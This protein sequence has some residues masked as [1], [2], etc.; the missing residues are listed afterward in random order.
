[1]ISVVSR[2]EYGIVLLVSLVFVMRCVDK[3]F[4][5]YNW[6][7]CNNKNC[8]YIKCVLVYITK[9]YPSVYY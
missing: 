1:M 2:Y 7:L 4:S 8:A 5:V 3:G 6:M 9:L